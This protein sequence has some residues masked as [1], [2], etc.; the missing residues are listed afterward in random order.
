MV[1]QALDVFDQ[2]VEVEW[3]RWRRDE[4][5]MLIEPAGVFVLGVDRQGADQGDC[6]TIGDLR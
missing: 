4:S 6:A 5:E 1:S 3:V 2:E